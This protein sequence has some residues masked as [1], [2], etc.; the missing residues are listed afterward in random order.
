MTRYNVSFKQQLSGTDEPGK[1]VSRKDVSKGQNTRVD[2]QNLSEFEVQQLTNANI[3]VVG[4]SK[5][6]PGTSE[7]DEVASKDGCFDLF[8]FEP[9][10]GINELRGVFLSGTDTSIFSWAS[11]GDFEVVSGSVNFGG[12]ITF[13]AFKTGGDGDVTLHGKDGTNW[14]EIKQD[15]T[16]TDL[17]NTSGTGADSPPQ[18]NVG[19][20]YNDRVWVLKDNKLYYCDALPGDYSNTF[21]TTAQV[22]NMAVGEERFL[23]GIRNK[24][25]ICGGK[26]LIR[27]INPSTTPAATDDYGILVDIGCE[28]GKTA[29]LVGDDILYLAKD[30]VRGI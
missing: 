2:P 18:S 24:G 20:F 4:R 5:A 6:I 7:I 21:S 25:L 14:I 22:Y 10:G 28:A 16:V 3:D 17:G 13:K 27:Y 23:L 15:G 8:G 26:N 9:D 30:G 29:K 11:A 19:T 12:G 1:F